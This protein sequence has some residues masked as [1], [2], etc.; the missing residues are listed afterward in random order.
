MNYG[1]IGHVIGHEITHG[2]DDQGKQF[3][4]DG[5]LVNWWNK[6]TQEKYLEKAKCIIYQ[7]GNYTDARSGLSVRSSH[8]EKNSIL[9]EK[10]N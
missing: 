4:A 7:Y 2:F 3:D 9:I 5:N 8:C 10:K 1:G 6:N